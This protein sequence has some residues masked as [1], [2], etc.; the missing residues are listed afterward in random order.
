MV[1][2]KASLAFHLSCDISHMYKDLSFSVYPPLIALASKSVSVDSKT[3]SYLK[4]NA[5][6]KAR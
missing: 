2:A 3:H 6:L 4:V 1:T 5:K